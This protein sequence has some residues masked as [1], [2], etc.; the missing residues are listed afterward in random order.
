MAGPEE[1][2]LYFRGLVSS[3]VT[4]QAAGS[5]GPGSILRSLST[6]SD[7][8]IGSL[9]TMQMVHLYRVGLVPINMGSFSHR[10]FGF[11]CVI[12]DNGLHQLNE[13]PTRDD[14]ILDLVN[15]PLIVDNLEVYIRFSQ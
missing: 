4:S 13:S 3:V 7:L 15:D 11:N 1:G 5:K 9:H 10:T 2:L 12:M 6:F 8:F 14:T